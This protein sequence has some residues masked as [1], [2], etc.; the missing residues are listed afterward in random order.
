MS[1]LGA[2]RTRRDG[3]NDVNDPNRTYTLRT[4]LGQLGDRHEGAEAGLHQLIA[5]AFAQHGIA[6]PG[7]PSQN[8]VMFL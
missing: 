7:W 4:A 6:D 8:P 3:G 5:A 1:A 2:N